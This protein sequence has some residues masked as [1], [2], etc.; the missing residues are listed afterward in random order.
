MKLKNIIKIGSFVVAGV[1]PVSASASDYMCLACPAGTYSNGGSTSCTPCPAGKYAPAASTECKTCPLGSYSA[2][3]ADSCTKCSDGTYSNGARTECVDLEPMYFNSV[4]S[5][6]GKRGGDSCS[7]V[8]LYPDRLYVVYLQGGDGAKYSDDCDDGCT[9][10]DGG[11]G[12]VVEYQFTVNKQTSA[13]LCA[14]S[15]SRKYSEEA[16]GGGAWIKIGD[17]YIIAG[18]GYSYAPDSS[19]IGS[20]KKIDSTSLFGGYTCSGTIGGGGTCLNS[21]D[22]NSHIYDYLRGCVPRR[23]VGCAYTSGEVYATLLWFDYEGMINAK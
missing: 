15:D 20:G 23:H 8:T 4:A 7:N 6:K 10:Y 9:W 22:S 17:R 11:S 19:R 13:Q 1:A 2:K 14:G 16:P 21:H 3:G 18:G 12:G 5:L